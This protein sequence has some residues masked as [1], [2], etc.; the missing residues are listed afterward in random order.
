MK[1]GLAALLVIA[2]GGTML[3]MYKASHHATEAS[4]A[5]PSASPPGSTGDPSIDALAKAGGDATKLALGQMGQQN[6]GM[7][8]TGYSPD[9]GFEPTGKWSVNVLAP[10]SGSMLL[11]LKADRTFSISKASDALKV[12]SDQTGGAGTWTFVVTTGRLVLLPGSGNFA[13]GIYIGGK[14]GSGFGAM[15]PDGVRYS[16]TRP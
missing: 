10:I 1:G 13:L 7:P 2:S 16:F 3:C 5:P 8:S 4:H 9:A 11:D 15:S 14:E 12:L 6:A